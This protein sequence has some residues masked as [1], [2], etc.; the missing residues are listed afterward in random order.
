VHVVPAGVHDARS[1]SPRGGAAFEDGQSVELG[2]QDDSGSGSRPDAEQP[3]G[4]RN[5]LGGN[6]ADR[7]A[8]GLGGVVLV[9]GQTRVGVQL[10]AQ[11]D[12][13]RQFGGDE[14]GQLTHHDS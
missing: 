4:L 10:V 12:C 9:A 14:F 6:I 13:R 5:A 11:P 7:G 8:H 2:A 3:A 1:R